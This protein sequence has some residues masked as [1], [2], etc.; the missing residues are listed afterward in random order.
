MPQKPDLA[1][2]EAWRRRLREF[3]RG[4]ATITEFCRRAGVP[5]WSFYYWQQR[6]RSGTSQS[7]SDPRRDRAA[8]PNRHARFGHGTRRGAIIPKLN[9]V[10]VQ[11]AGVRGVEVTGVRSVEVHLPNGTRVLVPGQD[12]DAIGAVMAA[13]LSD[14]HEGRGSLRAKDRP[15]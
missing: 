3:D 2:R 8:A 6:L 13:L 4:S 10:P 12:R 5:V 9:F 14:A 15:C 11:V 7:P 1:K